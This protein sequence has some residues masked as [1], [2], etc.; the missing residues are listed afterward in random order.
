[1]RHSRHSSPFGWTMNLQRRVEL[2]E[3][4]VVTRT[5]LLASFVDCVAENAP[6]VHALYATLPLDFAPDVQQMSR[7]PDDD[8]I[9]SFYP[10]GIASGEATQPP[11]GSFDPAEHAIT[12]LRA[13]QSLFT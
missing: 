2:H 12:A 10:R 5:E 7:T 11:Q 3:K 4:G 6:K 8:W 1:M 9:A 13:I